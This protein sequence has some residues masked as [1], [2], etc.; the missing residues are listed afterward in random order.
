MSY[1]PTTWQSGDTVTST[2]L[3]NI[4]QGISALDTAMSGKEN[5]LEVVTK[6]A[7]D[8]SQTLAADKFYVWPEMSEL[9]IT[10]PSTGLYGFRFTSGTTPTTFA[11]TGVTM[12]DDWTGTEA[13]TTYEM[14]ILNNYCLVS[15]WAV[16]GS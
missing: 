3:N 2:K 10:C 5:A 14:N 15:K 12:P 4:E 6:L 11:M 8:T 16:S 9:T 1:S 13:S 7:T